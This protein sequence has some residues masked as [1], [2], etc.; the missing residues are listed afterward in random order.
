MRGTA[1]MFDLPRGSA[2]AYYPEANVLAGRDV[3][4]RSRTPAFKSIAVTL[5]A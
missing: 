3:D 5:V 1:T 2:M 4:P